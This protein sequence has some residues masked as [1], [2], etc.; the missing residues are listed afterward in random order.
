MNN[1]IITFGEIMVRL[2]APSPLRLSQ[3][4]QLDLGFAGAEANVAVSLANYGMDVEYITR[5]PNNPIADKCLSDL[6]AM[7]VNTDKV[8]RGGDR[9]G[10]MYL[11]PGSNFRPSHVYYDRVNSAL[12]EMQPGMADWNTIFKDANWFHWTGITPA[13]SQGAAD[14]LKEAIR[15][16][17][18]KGVIVSCDINYRGNLWKYGKAASEVMPELVAMSDIILGNEEDCEKVFGIKPKGFDVEKTNGEIN[19]LIFESVCTQMMQKFPNCK[20]MVVTLRGAINANHNTWS[21]VLFDG[22][23]LLQSKQYDITNIVDRVGGGDSFMGGLIYG[24]MTYPADDQKA[25]EFAVAASALK[26]TIFGDFNRVSV[27]EVMALVE[28]NTSGRVKR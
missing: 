21:G 18:I 16:A 5:L 24:L 12:S 27:D 17:K 9:I 3:C 22:K 28:G 7:K 1:K 13:L 26:H 10:L 8:L 19:P 4:N 2:G 6:R 11:E 20:K 25:L 15:V 23:R 14:T